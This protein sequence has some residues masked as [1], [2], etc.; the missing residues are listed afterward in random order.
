P[1]PTASRAVANSLTRT[2]TAPMLGAVNEGDRLTHIDE[3]GRVHMVDVGAKPETERRA[4]A[5]AVVRMSPTTASE[6]VAGE[7]AE[8]DLLAAARIAGIQAAKRTGELIP[9]PHPQPP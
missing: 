5:E 8:G 1:A 2:L 3:R 7:A 4:G 9:L 6:G